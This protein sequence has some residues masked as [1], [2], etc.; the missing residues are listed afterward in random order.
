[1]HY[2]LINPTEKPTFGKDGTCEPLNIEEECDA[3]DLAFDII[4]DTI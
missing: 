2:N 4:V 3:E 1:M